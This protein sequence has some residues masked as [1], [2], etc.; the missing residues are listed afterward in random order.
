MGKGVILMDQKKIIA[1]LGSWVAN[2]VVFLIF[3]SIL[4]GNV[5]LGNDKVS[6]PMAAVLA[7]LLLSFVQFLVPSAVAR[8]GYKVKNQNAWA[9]IF[10]A[11]NF[12]GIWVIKRFALTTGLGVSN[13]AYVLVLAVVVTVF[14]WGVSQLT[15]SMS[16]KK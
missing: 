3:A 13:L 7:G 2:S 16:K 11:F 14:G 8:S 1:F 5:V 10:L 4:S 9:A 6:S 15:G 12:L